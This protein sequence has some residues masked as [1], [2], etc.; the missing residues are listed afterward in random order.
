MTK[1]AIGLTI[2]TMF[3][4]VSGSALAAQDFDYY[5]GTLLAPSNKIV[6]P[7]SPIPVSSASDIG[8]KSPTSAQISAMQ[9]NLNQIK[10]T[11]ANLNSSLAKSNSNSKLAVAKGIPL[12][13][14]EETKKEENTQSIFASLIPPD[15]RNFPFLS[16]YL[17]ILTL[18]LF[19]VIIYL[20][21]VRK[22]TKNQSV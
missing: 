10:S 16:T 4:S 6:S 19:G 22:Q 1:I 7:V 15:V 13:L 5:F 3:L 12:L 17:V 20:Y 9:A 11:L 14:G 8:K 18:T 2:I 21:F